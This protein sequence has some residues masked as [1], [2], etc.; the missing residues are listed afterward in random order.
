MK[1]SHCVMVSIMKLSRCVKICIMIQTQGLSISI[2]IR[3]VWLSHLYVIYS[4]IRM[5]LNSTTCIRFEAVRIKMSQTYNLKQ[6]S[7]QLNVIEH[8]RGVPPISVLF[9]ICQCCSNATMVW[10]ELKDPYEEFWCN[11]C[12][13]IHLFDMKYFFIW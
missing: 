2:M 7:F 12:T 6:G 1:E 13:Y 3:I 10:A 11:D 5:T 9:K 4:M 8:Q